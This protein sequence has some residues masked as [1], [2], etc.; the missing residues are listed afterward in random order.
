MGT[1]F[2]SVPGARSI[3]GAWAHR[4]R[5][6]GMKIALNSLVWELYFIPL[7][8]HKNSD[9]RS[10]LCRE[11]LYSPS[12][13][14]PSGKQDGVWEKGEESPNGGW[15]YTRTRCG[16]MNKLGAPCCF[17]SHLVM[18][19]QKSWLWLDVF[20]SHLICLHVIY[21]WYCCICT[22][23]FKLNRICFI[24]PIFVAKSAT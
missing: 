12:H 23:I 4:N 24:Y 21:R 1:C 22:T 9:R 8:C 16:N 11:Q 14:T 20:N 6:A 7:S 19:Q 2:I 10:T 17:R 5:H 13:S 15:R 18:L 3:F